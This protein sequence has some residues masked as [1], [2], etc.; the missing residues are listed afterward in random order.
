MRKTSLAFAGLLLLV[1]GLALT[2][3]A[4][5]TKNSIVVPDT[6]AGDQLLDAYLVGDWCTNRQETS[7][8]NRAAGHSSLV[9]VSPVF[10]HFAEDGDWDISTSG[11]L[12]DYYGSWQLEGRDTLLL[13]KEGTTPKKYQA[14][15]RNNG[16]DLYLKDDKD[17]FL[18][19]AHCD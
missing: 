1:A 7:V 17:Q 5:S 15:F 9:N 14:Q 4:C 16:A 2:L 13:A 19:I 3:G 10:W 18:V 12:F 8:A 6:Q 11:F